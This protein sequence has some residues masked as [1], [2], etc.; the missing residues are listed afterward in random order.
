MRAPIRGVCSSASRLLA[1]GPDDVAIRL[2]LSGPPSPWAHARCS[3]SPGSPLLR[4]LSRR[5]APDVTRSSKLIVASRGHRANPVARARPEIPHC[6]NNWPLPSTP[7]LIIDES[8]R[9]P[10]R[11]HLGVFSGGPHVMTGPGLLRSRRSSASGPPGACSCPAR[12]SRD[13]ILRVRVRE[14]FRATGSWWAARTGP[15]SRA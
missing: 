13:P 1:D 3:L 14:W 9:Q 11:P 12:L 4:G 5:P 8:R 2:A 10:D 7:S 15:E 6:Q